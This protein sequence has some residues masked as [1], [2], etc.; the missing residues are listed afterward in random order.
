MAFRF[1][2]NANFVYKV[3]YD[4]A[5]SASKIKTELCKCVRACIMN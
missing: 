2:L 3:A 1:L 4:M 5:I